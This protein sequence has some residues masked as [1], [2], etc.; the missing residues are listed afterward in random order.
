LIDT[1]HK[2]VDDDHAHGAES[3]S[4]VAVSIEVVGIDQPPGWFSHF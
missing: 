2:R 4:S 3:N 1:R